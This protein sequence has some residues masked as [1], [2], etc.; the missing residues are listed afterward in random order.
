M[1]DDWR[2]FALLASSFVILLSIFFNNIN[3]HLLNYAENTFNFQRQWKHLTYILH[4][5]CSVN[6][7]TFWKQPQSQRTKS[8]YHSSSVFL[9]FPCKQESF[10]NIR[11][12][13]WRGGPLLDCSSTIDWHDGEVVAF[14]LTKQYASEIITVN[15]SQCFMLK[16]TRS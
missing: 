10:S 8:L 3:L 1:E 5:R 7:N 4:N 2:C 6:E 13:L 14:T 11:L 9:L 15:K 16:K 12:R